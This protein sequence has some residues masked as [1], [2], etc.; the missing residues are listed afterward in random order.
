MRIV[1]KPKLSLREEIRDF[2]DLYHSLGQRAE[3]FLPRHIIDNLRSFTHLCYEEPDDP[4]LQE[5]EINRQLL[6]LK[7]AIPG[8]SDVSLMLFP[9]DESKAFEYR[10]KKNKFHQR[11]IS[12]IDT[13]A[14]NEDEQEQAKNILKC[15]DYSV[16][17]P[18]VTQTNLNFRYQILLGDQVSELRKFRE[19]IGIKDKVEE[20]QWNFLLDVLDQMVIQSSHYTTAAEKTDFLIRSEQTINFKGLNGFLKTV[21]SGSSD[22]AVKLLK[23]E[24]FNPV[25][26]KEINFTDEES[27]Y[28]AINGDKTSIFAIRI[29]YLRKNLF[30]H[31]RWFP[32]LTRMIFIDTSDVSKSTNTT[33]VFCLHN[34]IIQ[35]LNKVHTKKLGA[36]AN[37]QLNLRLIL[38][39]VSKRNLEHFKTLIENKIE[40]YRNEI[41]LLKKEQLGT[42]TDLEKDIVLF[43]FDEFSRQILKDKYTLEKLRDY[44][45]LILNC[46]SV[47]TIKEQNKRLIQEFEERTKKYFYSENDQV[48]IATIVEG[49]GRNQIKTYG[50]Y[51]LQRKLKAVDQ[52]IIDRCRVILEVIPDTYQRTLKNHFHKNFGVNLFLEK[53]KQY[54]IKVENEADNTGRFNNFLIDLGIYDKYNQLSKKEQNIIKEFISNLSN[55]NKT[56]IS[57]DVQMIIRDVLFG[58]EDKVL[59]PYILFNKYSS[60]E[61]M[62]LFPTDR[63]DINPFDLEIGINEEGRIDYDRLTNRLERM[64]KTFQVFDE[65][66]N[67]WDSFCENLTIVINDPANP[68]GYS[69]FN[70]RSL[71]RFLKFI[72]SSKIT[73]FL[74]E[75]YNDSVKIDNENEPKWRTISRYVM[76]NL[77]QQYARINLVSSISTTKN[78]GA[79]G[80]RLGSII[81]TPAKKD[82]ID[83][84][85][86]QNSPEK[87]NTNSLF[88]LVNILENAQLAKS[89]KDN[90]EERLPKNASRNKIK[91]R[92]EQYIIAEIISYNRKQKTKNSKELLR[93]SP[94]EGSP[95]HLFLLNEL[96]ALDKLDVLELPDDFKYKDEIFF[97][98]YQKQLVKE[99]NKFRVNKNF[100]NE[101]LLRLKI[102][103]ETAAELLKGEAGEHARIIASDG[104]FLFNI[105]L[106]HFFS[107]QDLEKFTKKLAES[108]GIAVIPYQTGFLRFSMGDYLDGTAKGYEIFKKEFENA[109]EIVLKYWLKFYEA[110]N[111]PKNKEL[112]SDEI[113]EELFRSDSD[114]EFVKQVLDDF[115]IVKNLK[116]TLSNSLRINNVWTL[117][118]ASPEMSGVSINSIGNSKNSVIEFSEEV[119]KCT[120]LITFIRSIAFTSVYENLLP[121]IYKNI[122][123]IKHLDFG[124][125]LAR[126]GKSTLLKYITNKLEYQPTDYVLDAPEDDI[127]MAEVLL[128]MENILFSPSKTKIL[129]LNSTGRHYEDIA[130]LEGI[131][132]IMR[133]YIQEL[134]LH[135]NLPFEN[136][137]V[138]PALEELLEKTLEKFEKVTG[139][140]SED[141]NLSYTLKQLSESIF[142]AL[143]KS[144]LQAGMKLYGFIEKMI[145]KKVLEGEGS[146]N[147][148]IIKLYLLKHKDFFKNKVVALLGRFNEQLNT[149]DDLE[150]E[151]IIGEFLQKLLPGEIE[152]L[153]T[154]VLDKG[155]HNIEED[156]LHKE[157]RWFTLFII[158]L[159]NQTKSNEHYDR[160]THSVIR[161][162]EA[163][164]AQQNSAINEV[165]QHGI[166][167]Y[168][169]F[170]SKEHPLN[171]YR[172]GDL[173]W[174]VDL[175]SKSGV[176][177]TEKNVQTHT[178]IA[179]DAK[180]REYAF[181]KIDRKK[182]G[183]DEA[184]K[185][186]ALAIAEENSKEYVKYLN[187]R[188]LK[189]F[190]INR[191]EKF[192][193][194]MD[195]D[196]YRCKIFNGGLLNELFIYHKSFMKYMADNYRLLEL[197]DVSLKEVKNFIP[198]TICLYG[199]PEKVIS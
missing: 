114:R 189:N 74:D 86:K 113:L 77:N 27:L 12:L 57:D 98:Y 104:S 187:T 126:Y 51:L 145:N 89:I 36:L 59:K 137:P 121:Q 66:G 24:L 90:L 8:Y 157:I 177:A 68:S 97:T 185:E 197:Q 92:I 55:L 141:I 111:D 64:K 96:V 163:E 73:L 82:V 169:N 76:N 123:M 194:N 122:P 153:W 67:L 48:Q 44:L 174:I 35:T 119:G 196:D 2:I 60:W 115:Y 164:F 100:R 61:Y 69:D 167:T 154:Q 71:L 140:R 125:V 108:R 106:K 186:K 7:E 42:I 11:L 4:I 171:E 17:T 134:M 172:N 23:E 155:K 193:S 53:Y 81:A 143:H 50:E 138:E 161:L 166:T 112:S 146:A 78:F 150:I 26:V 72:S 88:M 109:L 83:F 158:N 133:K 22:T 3:N 56:S 110:K 132:M 184:I 47:S 162:T 41:T 43:K 94:F 14:I 152:E 195:M 151:S 75:A 99:I 147:K 130:R 34:K 120:D 160:Y 144:E 131:N 30:N 31:R 49:G 80:D 15:H 191:F 33:L 37:S 148:K 28:K 79:T 135:F 159:M 190:F 39:K 180:K 52:D 10:T 107:Y 188:P 46:T 173:R 176:I 18:P 175:M 20:A 170:E 70:N 105:Q 38:E 87:G 101:A 103:K 179:T 32:L 182:G 40:D 198:D 21:V 62:D 1:G 139:I 95:L 117:Y 118:H 58:K 9:H 142:S 65:S 6:E 85:R 168:K 16:G 178:R 91:M 156:H 128:E 127:I 102:A 165:I 181:H 192:V 129:T 183:A 54:L 13:E 199:A 84:A 116:K 124:T 63:F 149:L 25:I 45:D 19:V 29:P 5:K 136:D 93:F